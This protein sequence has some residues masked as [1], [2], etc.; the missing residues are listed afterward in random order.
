MGPKGVLLRHTCACTF[1]P[2][3]QL[4]STQTSRRPNATRHRVRGTSMLVKSQQRSSVIS[5]AS[6][7][8]IIY[9]YNYTIYD[10]LHY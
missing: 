8:S 2:Y 5:Q 1:A 9:H 3:T 7:L 10:T 4:P 6:I